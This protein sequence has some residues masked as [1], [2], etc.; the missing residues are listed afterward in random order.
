MVKAAMVSAATSAHTPH[1]RRAAVRFL[2]GLPTVPTRH[3]L[4]RCEVSMAADRLGT[5]TASVAGLAPRPEPKPR[6]A[7]SPRLLTF[8]SVRREG[9]NPNLPTAPEHARDGGTT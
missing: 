3:Y 5:V 6:T 8:V 1:A 7:R 4:P 9:F 2:T